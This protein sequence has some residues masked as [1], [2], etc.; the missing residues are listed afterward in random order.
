[1]LTLLLASSV[2]FAF[3]ASFCAAAS[4]GLLRLALQPLQGDLLLLAQVLRRYDV[5]VL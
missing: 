5:R 1:L 2:R 3:L 4:V